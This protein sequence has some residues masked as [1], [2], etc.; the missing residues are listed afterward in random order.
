MEGTS[1]I[2]KLTP[3]MPG[4]ITTSLQFVVLNFAQS[5]SQISAV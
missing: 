1:G 4:I 2:V 5:K 3:G